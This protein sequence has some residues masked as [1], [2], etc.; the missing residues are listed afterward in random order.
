MAVGPLVNKSTRDKVESL[1]DDAVAKGAKVT[2][3]GKRAEGPG[4]FYPPTVLTNVSADANLVWEEIFGPVAAIQTFSDEDAMVEQCNKS[5][6][7][8]ASYVYTGDLKRACAWR[9]A[10]RPAWSA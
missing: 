5:E 6:Y 4:Y 10:W 8:L 3:G 9:R 1:V 7:G 2:T